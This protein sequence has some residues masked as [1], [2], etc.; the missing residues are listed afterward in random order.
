MASPPPAPPAPPAPPSSRLPRLAAATQSGAY[1]LRA[2]A[3][4]VGEDWLVCIWGGERPHLG[5]VAMATPRP[6]L[7]EAG[8][9]SA[10]ASVF[11]YVG[12]K[13]DELAKAAAERLAAGLD[14]KV[15]VAAGMHWEAID[16]KGIQKVREN[17]Q[18]LVA[19]LLVK[20]AG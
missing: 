17:C 15:V 9:T 13:E 11:C 18:Q 14:A 1:D 12:H 2:E 4:L 8:R 5:A 10:T 3:M 6:S 7:A 20:M 16:A 19:E